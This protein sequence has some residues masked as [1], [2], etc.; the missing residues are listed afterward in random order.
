M[1]YAELTEFALR[2]AVF[3]MATSHQPLDVVEKE[4]ISHV[5]TMVKGS[6][7][8]SEQAGQLN[9]QQE[10]ISLAITSIKFAYGA[11]SMQLERLG[12]ARL[13]FDKER[14][15]GIATFFIPSDKEDKDLSAEQATIRAYKELFD[16]SPEL[17]EFLGLRTDALEAQGKQHPGEFF[18]C[19]PYYL[20]SKKLPTSYCSKKPSDIVNRSIAL[21]FKTEL[22]R[23]IEEI[24]EDFDDNWKFVDFFRS[25]WKK[26]N[27]LNNLRGPRLIIMTLG[28]LLWNL[29]H[30]IDIRTGFS[31]TLDEKIALCEKVSLLINRLLNKHQPPNLYKFDYD[32]TFISFVA[33]VETY[34]QRLLKA[35]KTEKIDS[36]E[37]SEVANK[38][39]TT[40]RILNNNIFKLIYKADD[41]APRL[42]Q[43]ID[44][45]NMLIREDKGIMQAISEAGYVSSINNNPAVTIADAIIIFTNL[46]AR[47]QKRLIK[48]LA[49]S[50]S[51]AK[52]NFSTSIKQ[53]REV[54]LKPIYKHFAKKKKVHK[55]KKDSRWLTRVSANHILPLIGLAIRDYRVD[56]SVCESV[57]EQLH[58]KKNRFKSAKATFDEITEAAYANEKAGRF[59]FS[60]SLSSYLSVHPSAQDEIDELPLRQHRIGKITELIDAI[61]HFVSHYRS[62]LQHKAFKD[63][64]LNA[65]KHIG[66][67]FHGLQRLLHQLESAINQNTT[68]NRTLID[69]ISSMD[70]SLRGEIGKFSTIIESL[71]TKMNS[72]Q[73]EERI[74]R[75]IINELKGLD[76]QFKRALDVKQSGLMP[77]VMSYQKELPEETRPTG[78]MAPESAAASRESGTDIAEYAAL[79]ASLHGALS[80]SSKEGRKGRMLLDLK[81]RILAKTALT[82][83][84]KK[85]LLQE[86]ARIVCAYRVSFF[87]HADY[88]KTRSAKV[89]ISL[90][91]ESLNPGR[92]PFAQALFS[93]SDC[94]EIE[95]AA[96]PRYNIEHKL[97]RLMQANTWASDESHLQ[98]S[99]LFA[100][101]T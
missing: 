17:L 96:N 101:S 18:S 4:A 13:R 61:D 8:A 66:E 86:L 41:M 11:V 88:A 21:F 70:E 16:E 27:F 50:P 34:V 37:L 38:A 10:A 28:N 73:F 44:F 84:E 78:M 69:S 59:G 52:R 24:D 65:L 31:L 19:L 90:L 98:S 60:W 53:F 80:A 89:F 36:L 35:Y 29:Q 75:E 39:H 6:L 45:M 72:P 30:P 67:E 3:G 63:F 32:G 1:A 25:S 33:Q 43:S 48:Q 93:H 58:K 15:S 7:S 95:K 40:A 55:D 23:Y 2:K 57:R 82:T 46:S 9:L 97:N 99:T 87:F 51:Q 12:R 68:S 54:F 85:L 77:F 64:L 47:Q 62:F 56:V 22:P 83:G 26:E 91:S 20:M 76:A 74:K 5:A 94:V 42:A 14:K 81:Q 79:V 100:L 71:E 92:Y 49:D